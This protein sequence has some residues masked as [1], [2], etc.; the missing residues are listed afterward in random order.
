MEIFLAAIIGIIVLLVFIALDKKSSELFLEH[1]D[2]IPEGGLVGW[3]WRK[4][5][6][7]K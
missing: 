5:F 6:H 1:K 2:K 7:K 4:L 3:L